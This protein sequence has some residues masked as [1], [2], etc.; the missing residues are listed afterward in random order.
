MYSEIGLKDGYLT[1]NRESGTDTAFTIFLCLTWSNIIMTC[2]KGVL[3][4]II[5]NESI[6]NMG[7]TIF[8]IAMILISIPIFVSSIKKG[9]YLIYLAFV[10]IWIISGV[11]HPA[12]QQW[13]FDINNIYSVL[14]KI[15][16]FFFIGLVLNEKYIYK[17]YIISIVSIYF[18]FIYAFVFH[19]LTVGNG[20]VSDMYAAYSLLV[21]VSLVF[22]YNFKNPSV[23]GVITVVAGLV[24]QIGLGT[25]GAVGC[26][27]ALFIFLFLY[28]GKFTIRQ[29]IVAFAIIIPIAFLVYKNIDVI[30]D[31][32]SSLLD[33]MGMSTRIVDSFKSSDI[34]DDNGRNNIAEFFREKVKDNPNG[35][36][37]GY[38]RMFDFTPYAHNFRMEL[39]V[40]F[41][42][43]FGN[44][45]FLIFTGLFVISMLIEKRRE[46]ALLMAVLFFGV[47][48]MQLIVSNSYLREPGFWLLLGLSV[49]TITF[50]LENKRIMKQFKLSDFRQDYE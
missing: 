3:R 25:R 42:V 28:G 9:A 18:Y 48:Y 23:F 43:V 39:L 40:S 4:H 24:V 31:S 15:V 38:D 33:S 45:A 30:M 29:K 35:Y 21:H 5:G 10:L 22:A 17:M 11:L 2:F 13:V 7:I 46:N 6:I 49:S 19:R 50:N 14:I 12:T 34:T 36:G 1:I 27:I 44:A 47:G 8:I 16:P 32:L 26:F 37:I 41:G 20:T